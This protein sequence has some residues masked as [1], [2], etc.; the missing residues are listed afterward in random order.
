MKSFQEFLN[1][2]KEMKGDFG[3]DIKMS[4]QPIKCYGKTVKYKMAP[5][6]KVCSFKRKR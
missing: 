4:D 5:E 3:A 1:I 2:L 6:K